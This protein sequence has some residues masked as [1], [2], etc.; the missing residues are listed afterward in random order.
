[1]SNIYFSIEENET[2]KYLNIDELYEKKQQQ[3]L[4][5]LKLFNNILAKVHKKI[6]QEAKKNVKLCMYLVP[7]IIL[8][9]PNYDNAGCIAFLLFHLKEN[10]FLVRYTHPNLLIISWDHLIPSYVR[11]EIKKKTGITV[12][13]F[14]KIEDPTEEELAEEEDHDIKTQGELSYKIN[15]KKKEYKSVQSYKPTGGLV[16]DDELIESI[17]NKIG[18]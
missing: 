4:K 18:K 5:Q 9:A 17:T 3:D 16:Y 7:E 12:D 14:G 11:N 15:M 13:K 8:N 10:G 6:K 1:M 2:S